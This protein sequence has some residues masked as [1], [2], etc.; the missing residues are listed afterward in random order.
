MSIP[1]NPSTKGLAD[2]LTTVG[3]HVKTS[4]YK[5]YDWNIKTPISSQKL[6]ESEFKKLSR[7][8]QFFREGHYTTEQIAE[9]QKNAKAAKE[10][11][12]A[13][14]EASKLAKET[15]KIAK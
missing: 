1:S 11:E 2:C 6:P 4:K 13:A 12:K 15:S 5:F 14:K 10:A 9:I 8:A 7:A 3:K